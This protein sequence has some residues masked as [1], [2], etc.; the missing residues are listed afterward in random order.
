MPG[1]LKSNSK[2]WSVGQVLFTDFDKVPKSQRWHKLSFFNVSQKADLREP[3]L[4]QSTVRSLSRESV[5]R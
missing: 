5:R 1:I 3:E 4:I 2:I